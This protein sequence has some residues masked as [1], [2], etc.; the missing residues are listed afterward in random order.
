MSSLHST[1]SC[2]HSTWPKLAVLRHGYTALHAEYTI[3]SPFWPYAV[4]AII[5]FVT[6]TAQQALHSPSMAA[7]VS[8]I[9][10]FFNEE[11][12]SVV[13]HL[14]RMLPEVGEERKALL[15]LLFG[16]REHHLFVASAIFTACWSL[17]SRSLLRN[18]AFLCLSDMGSSTVGIYSSTMKVERWC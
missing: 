17:M 1:T 2:C 16:L 9:N 5:S 15:K 3:P 6:I 8:L 12:A 13:G 11:C 10:S 18:Y 7:Q 14:S 4:M